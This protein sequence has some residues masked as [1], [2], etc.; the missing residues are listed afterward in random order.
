MVVPGVRQSLGDARNTLFVFEAF[1]TQP[2]GLHNLQL[3]SFAA[4]HGYQGEIS[5]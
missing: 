3:I 5:K 1:L 4:H 2:Y